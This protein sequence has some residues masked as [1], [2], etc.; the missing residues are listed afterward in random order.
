MSKRINFTTYE[1]SL[2]PIFDALMPNPNITFNPKTGIITRDYI[3][4][5]GN[6]F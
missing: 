4:S 3:N 2:V 6:V 5:T 1:S